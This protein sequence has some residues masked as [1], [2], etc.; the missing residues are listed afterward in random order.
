MIVVQS[1]SGELNNYGLLGLVVIA[2]M[3]FATIMMWRV[4][5]YVKRSENVVIVKHNS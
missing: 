2:S 4:D 5:Q 3:I 1:A